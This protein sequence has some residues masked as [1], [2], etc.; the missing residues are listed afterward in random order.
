M[1]S[2]VPKENPICYFADPTFKNFSWVPN[3]QNHRPL[4]RG[5]LTWQLGKLRLDRTLTH[6]WFQSMV[7]TEC[8]LADLKP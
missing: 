1:M 2:V 6:P 8:W 7:A 4:W 5:M 3:P